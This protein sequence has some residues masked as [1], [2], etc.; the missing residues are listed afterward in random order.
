MND[1]D[2]NFIKSAEETECLRKAR[3]AQLNMNLPRETLEAFYGQVWSTEELK[4][5]WNIV[6]FVSPLVLV[7]SRADGSTGSFEFQDSPRF[8]FNYVRDEE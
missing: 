1:D 4:A 2:I 5:Q 7:K 6:T 8:Y 3:A